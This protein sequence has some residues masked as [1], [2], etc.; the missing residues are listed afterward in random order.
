V[1][2]LDAADLGAVALQDLGRVVER[3]PN[4]LA[5]PSQ[6]T[7]QQPAADGGYLGDQFYSLAT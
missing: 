6:L 1:A 4:G 3:V 2:G 5:Q 7:A